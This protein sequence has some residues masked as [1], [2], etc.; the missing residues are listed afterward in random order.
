MVAVSRQIAVRV[1]NRLDRSDET[2]EVVLA[3][4]ASEVPGLARR[5]RALVNELVFGVLRWR[6]RLD[7]MIEKLASRPL[8]K[9]RRGVMNILRLGLYQLVFLTRI[10][11]SA[12]VN[13]CVTLAKQTD[14]PWVASFVNAVLRAASSKAEAI[15]KPPT[16]GDP[17]TALAVW[18]SHPRWMVDRWVGRM[19]LDETAALCRAN[20]RVP[21]VALRAN[22]VKV[23]RN[24]LRDALLPHVKDIRVGRFS[25]D[26]L[27]LKGLKRPLVEMPGFRKGWFQ[28]QD[29]AAQLVSYLV[30]PRPGDRVLDACAGLGGKTGHLVQLMKDKG[31]VVA[32][33]RD[34]RKLRELEA[35]L[36]RCE[37]SSVQTRRLD[38]LK[39]D[40]KNL[41]GTFDKA[42]LDAPCSGL[43]VI[44]RHPDTKWR[45]RAGDLKRL[46]G[47]QRALL[48]A[49]AAWMGPGARLVYCVCSLEPEETE[50]VVEGFLKTHTDFAIENGPTEPPAEPVEALIDRAGVFRSLPHRHD[51]DG[52]FAVRL[53][54]MK[55]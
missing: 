8:R 40:S 44:R 33:D 20:N 14:A 16:G 1:L 6:G 41:L 18:E 54:R 39:P 45:K 47:M 46:S 24:D 27:I 3:Q 9:I 51:M 29:E 10:P 7:W 38:L 34:G 13:E 5:D 22:R 11:P 2:P 19:G 21:G 26:A 49:A 23:S 52:F 30:N 17:V 4:T 37:V 15:S 32:V 35:T 55:W 12:A 36:A 43:G 25:P 28:V 50:A 31:E 42:L 48:D 53:K